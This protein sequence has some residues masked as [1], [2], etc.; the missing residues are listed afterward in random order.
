SVGVI[1]VVRYLDSLL[2]GRR[3][4]EKFSRD[5]GWQVLVRAEDRGIS[6]T[7]G[8]HHNIIY[9]ALE[10]LAVIV[11]LPTTHLL[12]G[13]VDFKNSA[14]LLCARE[15]EC[16]LFGERQAVMAA[17]RSMIQHRGRF[18]VP[19]RQRVGYPANVLKIA[20]N[21]QRTLGSKDIADDDF[22]VGTRCP[23]NQHCPNGEADNFRCSHFDSFPVSSGSTQHLFGA[24]R[25]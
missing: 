21:V 13:Q 18:A 20:V 25:C 4:I 2:A 5:G 3:E 24:D 19:F 9:A 12:A 16:L 8:G 7:I 10:W 14:M 17:P 23:S 22:F 15:Q 1:E 6:T 11:G